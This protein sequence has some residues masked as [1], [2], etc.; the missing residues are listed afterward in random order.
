M[1][2][3]AVMINPSNVTTPCTH[4]K[5]CLCSVRCK[6]MRHYDSMHSPGRH[7]CCYNTLQ[8]QH[9]FKVRMSVS[10]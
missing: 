5:D 3:L 9:P 6:I 4:V 8:G 2:E 7:K 10:D 1:V